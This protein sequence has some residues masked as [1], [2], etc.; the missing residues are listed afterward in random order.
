MKVLLYICQQIWKIQQWSQ[1]WKKS[2]FI[3][4][5]KKGNAKECSNC[6]TIVLIS[7]AS[8]V[9]L[10]ILQVR[11]Q[12]YVNF[13]IFKLD[14]KRQKNQRSNCQFICRII[15]KQGNSRKTSTTAILAM[16]KPLTVWI[17]EICGKFL[18]RKKCQTTLPA[19]C[20]TCMQVKKKVRARHRTADWELGKEYIKDV[21]CHLAYLIYIQS[22]SCKML[23]WVRQKLELRLPGE[24]SITLDMQMTPLLWQKTNR[25]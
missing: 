23:G 12:Q 17:T 13:H 5:P 6:C 14:I 3:S 7:H 22:T 4:I 8:E 15:S 1:E 25:N 16:L 2:V 11:I 18:K 21:Y 19:S 20:E 9:V 10:K 24:I